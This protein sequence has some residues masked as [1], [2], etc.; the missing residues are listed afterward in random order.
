MPP[1]PVLP[2]AGSPPGAGLGGGGC[3]HKRCCSA[4]E[5]PLGLGPFGRV[6]SAGFLSSSL[7]L[8]KPEQ[9]CQK[10]LHC[11]L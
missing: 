3:R 2:C 7:F 6:D 11:N 10:L 5:S 4:R 8:L 1:P 9:E